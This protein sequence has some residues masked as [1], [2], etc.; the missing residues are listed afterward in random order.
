[1]VVRGLFVCLIVGALIV[2]NGGVATLKITHP[3]GQTARALCL[4]ST[5]LLMILSVERL[6]LG[7]VFA[8]NHAS[9]LILTAMAAVIL[10]ER[11]GWRRWNAVGTGFAGV[12]VMLRPTAAAFQ[13]T[14]H[15]LHRER[16]R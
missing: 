12:L 3:F 9:P 15:I 1:M 10:L 11:V 14:A 5:T 4:A 13:G 8:I 6:P 16:R 7:D 2:R